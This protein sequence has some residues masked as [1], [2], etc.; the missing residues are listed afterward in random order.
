MSKFRSWTLRAAA[1][2]VA[3]CGGTIQSSAAE[4]PGAAGASETA[5]H[6]VATGI[7]SPLLPPTAAVPAPA[8]VAVPAPIPAAFD[9]DAL[10]PGD[11]V[12][13]PERSPTGPVEIV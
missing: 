1:V 7:V 8:P 12:W 6:P 3:L 10:D 11:Y 5:Q 4:Y 9:P 2:A 13:Q